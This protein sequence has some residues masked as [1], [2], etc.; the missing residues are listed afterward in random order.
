MREY[1][2]TDEIPETEDE[3]RIHEAIGEGLRQGLEDLSLHHQARDVFTQLHKLIARVREEALKE[4]FEDGFHCADSAQWQD[5][6]QAYKERK[7]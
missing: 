1:I 7:G 4:G 2:D 5:W 6:K 3:A